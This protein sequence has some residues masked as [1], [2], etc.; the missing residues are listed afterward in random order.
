MDAVDAEVI[1]VNSE[2]CPLVQFI[3]STNNFTR[4]TLTR[5]HRTPHHTRNVAVS[6][7]SMQVGPPCDKYNVTRKILFITYK[8]RRY[9]HCSLGSSGRVVVEL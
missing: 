1:G 2:Q 9:M 6:S 5:S 8:I 3:N 7:V 4:S